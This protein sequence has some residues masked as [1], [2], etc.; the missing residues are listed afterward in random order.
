M[1][2]QLQSYAKYLDSSV[3][4]AK[5]HTFAYK[6]RWIVTQEELLI[7]LND[8]EWNG[9]DVK[10]AIGG[11]GKIMLRRELSVERVAVW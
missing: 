5:I 6:Y 4:L 1:I 7:R 2:A 11:I 10:E 3:L 9:L 8:I